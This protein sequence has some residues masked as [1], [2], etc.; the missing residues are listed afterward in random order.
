MLTIEIAPHRSELYQ[1]AVK[2][3]RRI[4]RVPL[5]LDFSPE[6][7]DHEASDKHFVG[8]VDDQVVACLVMA[9]QNCSVVKMRQVAVDASLQGQGLGSKLVQASEA[10][11]KE[12]GYS[13]IELN[14]RDTAVQFYESLDYRIVG[15]EFVE[16]GIPHRKMVKDI[17]AYPE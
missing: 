2:L 10:W 8:L 7:L 17:A 9:P 15:E 13:Q 16:V 6:E 14:A 4:L 3:R 1:Q 5:G 11:A 12:A